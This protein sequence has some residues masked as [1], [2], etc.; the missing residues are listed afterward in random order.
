MIISWISPETL[1]QQFALCGVTEASSVV[2]LTDNLVTDLVQANNHDGLQKLGCRV[3]FFNIQWNQKET[4]SIKLQSESLRGALTQADLVIDLTNSLTNEVLENSPLNQ[5]RILCIHTSE[6]EPYSHSMT[7]AGVLQRSNRIHTLLLNTDHVSINSEAGTNLVFSIDALSHDSYTGVPKEEGDLAIWPTG[8][9]IFS[10]DAAGL[11]G[12]IVLMPGDIVND[13][14]HLVKSPVVLQIRGG[15]IV[16]IVGESSDAN[17]L[18]AQLESFADREHAYML[19]GFSIGLLYFRGD[20]FSGPFDPKK[21][22]AVGA[23]LRGG[24]TTL[25]FG[26]DIANSL[27]VT[28]TSPN[29]LFDNVEVFL[30]GDF[31]ATMEPDIYELALMG[32]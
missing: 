32:L 23:T 8:Y 19:K 26:N 20:C 24:W 16:E 25:N 31:A 22:S 7:S 29:L 11:E 14:L 5:K 12:E 21:V 4:T 2:V 27:A 17:L 13:A 15:N 1:S 10:A 6:F 9:L 28:L 30:N 18:K 3:D